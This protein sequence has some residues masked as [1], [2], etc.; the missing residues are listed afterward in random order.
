[1]FRLS[2]AF[3]FVTGRKTRRPVTGYL[4]HEDGKEAKR[5][6]SVNTL[7]IIINYCRL[8]FKEPQRI[9]CRGS[10]VLMGTNASGTT[11]AIWT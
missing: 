9:W 5:R 4:R 3:T 6:T 7:K 10:V 11:E 2:P 1:L 8:L